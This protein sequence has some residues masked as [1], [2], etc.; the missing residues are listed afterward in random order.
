MIEIIPNW[1]PIF[2]HFTVALLSSSV[3]F[4]LLS[5]VDPAAARR[6]RWLTLGQWN[7]WLGV[8]IS[9]LTVGAGIY[10]FN[11]VDHDT[12]SHE[13]M[14]EHRNWALPTF[15]YFLA[16]AVWAWRDARRTLGVSTVFVAAMVL[17]AGLLMSTAWHGAELVYRHGLGVMSLPKVEGEGHA[18]EHAGG[19]EHAHAA[20]SGAAP[21]TMTLDA[22]APHPHD[23]DG[24]GHDAAESA[25][26][27]DTPVEIL[28]E[29]DDGHDHSH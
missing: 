25:P 20:P 29:H 2:V 26:M 7:L 14:I 23:E 6:E 28:D 24:H 9:L 21:A 5:R 1:H 19:G 4:F 8:A 16:M 12:P 27:Q 17:G 18:H 3:L 15:V 11:T 22:G 13:A 10:A